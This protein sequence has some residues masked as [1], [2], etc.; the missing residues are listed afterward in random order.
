MNDTK[1][2]GATGVDGDGNNV[3]LTSDRG[4]MQYWSSAIF[5]IGPSDIARRRVTSGGEVPDVNVGT[6]ATVE[7]FFFGDSGGSTPCNG[8]SNVLSAGPGDGGADGLDCDG[9]VVNLGRTFKSGLSF[10]QSFVTISTSSS[11]LLKSF[12]LLSSYL[13]SSNSSSEHSSDSSDNSP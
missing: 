3:R 1:R 4:G 8:E 5:S 9:V 13:S 12:S 2:S 10:V 11:Y 7:T 6:L